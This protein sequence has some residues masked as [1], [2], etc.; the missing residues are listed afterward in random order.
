MDV[1]LTSILANPDA[2]VLSAKSVT[3]SDLDSMTDAELKDHCMA[4]IDGID[5]RSHQPIRIA[6]FPC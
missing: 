6:S 1:T 2:R 3:H 4:A 5:T